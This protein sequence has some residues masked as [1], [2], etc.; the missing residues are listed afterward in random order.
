MLR[1]CGPVSEFVS[2]QETPPRWGFE[3]TPPSLTHASNSARA[4]LIAGSRR[5]YE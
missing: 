1:I 5:A 2:G 4:Q 3:T